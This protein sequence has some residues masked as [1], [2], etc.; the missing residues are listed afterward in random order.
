MRH[1][2]I[3]S[4]N[5]GIIISTFKMA[6]L[7]SQGFPILMALAL[8]FHGLRK[9][10]LSPSGALTAALV[11]IAMFTGGTRTFGVMLVGFYLLGSRA[12]KCAYVPPKILMNSS[13]ADRHVDGKARKAVLEDQHESGA[14]YRNGWQVLSNSFN[15]VVCCIAWN[16]AFSAQSIHAELFQYGGAKLALLQ[17]LGL[18]ASLEYTQEDWCPT[19]ANVGGGWS[20]ALVLA[21]LGCVS[22]LL[23]PSSSSS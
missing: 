2:A 7:R 12:T 5:A 11:G 16:V 20:R 17:F 19:D 10:S 15:A 14:G 21:T 8:A 13:G 4:Y 23:F 6:S 22:F 9:K 1:L 3:D 18:K